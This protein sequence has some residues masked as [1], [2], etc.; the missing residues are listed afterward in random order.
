MPAAPPVLPAHVLHRVLALS[1]IDGWGIVIVAGLSGT[2]TLVQGHGL[3][4]I[5]ALLVVMAG[6]GELLGRRR[7]LRRDPRGLDW[8]IGAQLFLLIVI[9]GYAWYRWRYFDPAALWA[10]LPGFAR[11]KLDRDLLAAGLD[12]ELDR[13]LLLD[14]MNTLTCFVLA[15]VSLVYQGGL[16]VYFATR[17]APVRQALLASPPPPA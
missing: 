5:A 8:M 9:W 1:R 14:L 3:V 15:L 11:A 7:L 13:A 16:A 17:R 6:A 12:P 10:E 4:T 2:V